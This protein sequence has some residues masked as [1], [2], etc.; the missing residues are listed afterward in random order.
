DI[1]ASMVDRLHAAGARVIG[2]TIILSEKQE[3]PVSGDLEQVIAL[4]RGSDNRS[5]PEL[6]KAIQMLESSKSKLD[7]DSVLASSFA[8]AENVVLGMQ[9]GLG[10][11]LGKLDQPLPDYVQKNKLPNVL[12]ENAAGHPAPANSATP[13][14]SSL[15]SGAAGIGHISFPIDPDGGIRRD[16]LVLDHYGD[17]FP[18]LSLMIAAESLNLG[19]QDILVKRGEAVNLANLEIKTDAVSRMYPFFYQD[20]AGKSAFKITSFYDV[21]VDKV[22]PEVFKDKIV[23]IGATAYGV[24]TSFVT[25]T[26]KAMTPAVLLANIVASILNQH[27]FI[28]PE[29]AYMVKWIAVLL[30]ALYLV[31]V[32]PRLNAK[33]AAIVSG[34]LLIALLASSQGLLIS[35]AMWVELMLPATLLACG[36]LLLITKRFLV[37]EKGKQKADEASAQSNRTLGLSYQQQG[38]LDMAWDKFQACP[39]DDSML[40]PL[41]SLALDFESK[42]KFAKAAMVYE[43]IAK[44][45]AK[46]KDVKE[47]IQR[48]K[49][50]QDTFV[51]GAP[52]A[53][54]GGAGTM[55]LDGDGGVQKPKL[56]RYEVEKELGKGAMGVVYLG[57]DPQIARTVAIK[58][59]ALSQEFEEDELDEVKE[60]FFR[61]AQTAGRLNHPNI[62]AIYDVGE[63]HDLAYIAMEFLEGHDLA[64]Y[65]KADALLPIPTVLSI[66]TLSADAL[67][68]AHQQNIVHRDIK[69]ANIMY[70]PESSK[71]KLTDFGIARI[72]DSSKTKTG[73]VLGTPSYMSPEQLSGKHVDGRS[74]LFSLGVMLYQLLSGDLPF[75][76][77]SMATLMFK[78]ANDPHPEIVS[79]KPEIAAKAPCVVSIVNKSL[80]K[81]PDQ[82]YQS[83]AEMSADLRSCLKAIKARKAG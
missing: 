78:I 22:K 79:V 40:E 42:R 16:L 33:L 44:Y 71:I 39:M 12:G 65:T 14:I 52:G 81:N 23:I 72:T 62:V 67:N 61:E 11:A 15:G 28:I 49:A 26:D 27:F 45:D 43:H 21:H 54:A 32:L 82:R 47:K 51:F 63:E 25:P 4:L 3:N 29:W 6:D 75:K 38:Q 53:A 10:R 80:E 60:R 20:E 73:M 64:R 76:G 8:Q 59:M 56:G 31:L 35:Q 57:K 9:F 24:G 70:V 50:M 18:S 58:T 13:P 2:S 37:T 30:I 34:V 48:S 36:Y 1:L 41:Y 66:I 7:T 69:P 46:Y 17:F 55:L 77:E 5:V 19:P 68:Y 83:G 74:D